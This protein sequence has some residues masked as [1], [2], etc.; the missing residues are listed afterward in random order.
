MYIG[1]CLGVL[2]VCT[3]F[4]LILVTRLCSDR[5]CV[6][7]NSPTLREVLTAKKR[8]YY[9]LHVSANPLNLTNQNKVNC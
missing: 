5:C 1:V 8:G 6:T 3:Y 7:H 9:G 2:I 4:L